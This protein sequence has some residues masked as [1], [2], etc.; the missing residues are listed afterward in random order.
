MRRVTS[1]ESITEETARGRAY[2]RTTPFNQ[3]VLVG[4]TLAGGKGR[5]GQLHSARRQTTFPGVPGQLANGILDGA[6]PFEGIAVGQRSAGLQGTATSA[7]APHTRTH[8][9]T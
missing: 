9:L 5:R 6:I 1:H 3:L 2:S 4:R 8:A 7:S